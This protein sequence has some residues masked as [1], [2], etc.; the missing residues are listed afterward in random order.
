M[1]RSEYLMMMDGPLEATPALYEGRGAALRFVRPTDRSDIPEGSQLHLLARCPGGWEIFLDGILETIA[2]FRAKSGRVLAYVSERALS[3]AAIAVGEADQ[4]MSTPRASF[5]WH[6]AAYGESLEGSSVSYRPV[7]VTHARQHFSRVAG[8]LAR[9]PR[10][11]VRAQMIAEFER[12]KRDHTNARD[13]VRWTAEQ[14]MEAGLVHVVP[15]E[16]ALAG[17]LL[18][19][20]NGK[21]S[22]NN[23]VVAPFFAPHY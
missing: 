16:K 14:L 6:A 13:E 1:S 4:L 20:S 15:D 12:A 3:A 22:P 2:Q 10:D 11:E 17:H 23:S 18:M 19:L 5:M 21:V 8:F 9:S 7:H